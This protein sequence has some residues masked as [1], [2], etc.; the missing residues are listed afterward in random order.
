MTNL[1]VVSCPRFALGVR[2]AEKW[3]PAWAIECFFD[4]RPA[5][6][7]VAQLC[8]KLSLVA[9][10]PAGYEDLLLVGENLTPL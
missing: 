1:L 5:A 9:A 4:G 7:P 8:L 3:L 10:G 6:R 2:K